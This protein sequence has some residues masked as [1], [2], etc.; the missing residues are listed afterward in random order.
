[1]MLIDILLNLFEDAAEIV[2]A[3]RNQGLLTTLISSQS[4]LKHLMLTQAS[5]KL[6]QMT[7]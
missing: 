7:L 6:F 3:V 1:M 2:V 5:L 4:T